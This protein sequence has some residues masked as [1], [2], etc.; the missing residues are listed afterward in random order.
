MVNSTNESLTDNEEGVS[1]VVDIHV[2]GVKALEGFRIW[3]KLSNG[4][5]GELDLA[6]YAEKPW[7]QPWQD[8]R[9]F[10]NVWIPAHGGDIRWGDDPEESDMGFLFNLALCGVDWAPLGR[11]RSQGQ[12]P[13]CSMSPL[14]LNMRRH[15]GSTHCEIEIAAVLRLHDVAVVDMHVTSVDIS[16]GHIPRLEFGSAPLQFSI[17]DQ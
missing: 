11:I 1:R 3:V 8:R 6:E 9:V 15:R 12:S 14:H 16:V 10:E 17:V 4:V 7:F 13:A 5:E 2:V